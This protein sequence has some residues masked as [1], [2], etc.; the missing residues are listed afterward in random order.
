MTELTQMFVFLCKYFFFIKIWR[1]LLFVKFGEN[2]GK[3]GSIW[4][5]FYIFK[6]HLGMYM[7]QNQKNFTEA[8]NKMIFGVCIA[9]LL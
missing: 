1:K 9:F 5:N 7:E 6:L 8:L 4:V 3:F 2:F